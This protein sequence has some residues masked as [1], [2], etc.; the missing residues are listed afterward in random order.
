MSQCMRFPTIWYVQPA[1]PQISL[2]IP[3]VWSEPLLVTWIF[4]ECWASDRTSFGGSKL[5]RRLQRLFYR[6]ST[7]VKMPHCWKSHAAARIILRALYVTRINTSATLSFN[8]DTQQLP[9]LNFL[10]KAC[11]YLCIF[12][13]I[14]IYIPFERSLFCI[15]CLICQIWH[16]CRA[17]QEWQWRNSCLQLLSKTLTWILHL[18]YSESVDHL[19]INPIL[20]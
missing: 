17:N 19:C 20:W 6:K 13:F 7:L 2:R 5:N 8:A 16:Y 11:L 1:K 14:F 12:Y 4:Y 10:S 15:S 18:S 3:T 9:T